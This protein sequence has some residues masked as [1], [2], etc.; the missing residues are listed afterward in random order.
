VYFHPDS[1]IFPKIEF[2]ADL[3]RERLEIASYLHKGVRIT[4]DDQVS[5]RK[6]VFAHDEGIVAYLQKL[7]VARGARAVHDT[8][9][10]LSK[11]GG[12]A[13]PRAS[14]PRRPTS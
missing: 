1:T 3:I 12:E 9:F 14:G 5:S 10:P 4:F 6:D 7:V 8:V 13:R 11:E 2:D